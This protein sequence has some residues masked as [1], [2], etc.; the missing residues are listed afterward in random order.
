MISFVGSAAPTA[1]FGDH[2]TAGGSGLHRLSEA[3]AAGAQRRTA[4][5]RFLVSRGMSA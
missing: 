5:P 3:T 2:Q 1:A 4:A